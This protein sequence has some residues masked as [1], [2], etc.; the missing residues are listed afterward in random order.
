[1]S[2]GVNGPKK[3][4][5]R[6]YPGDNP[7]AVDD[8]DELAESLENEF[9]KFDA[10]TAKPVTMESEYRHSEPGEARMREVVV[11]SFGLSEKE[12]WE[13]VDKQEIVT[14]EDVT[15]SDS[16]DKVRVT[17]YWEVAPDMELIRDLGRSLKNFAEQRQAH[18]REESACEE[19]KSGTSNSVE[20]EPKKGEEVLTELDPEEEK[21]KAAAA[22]LNAK[23]GLGMV[24]ETTELGRYAA[25]VVGENSEP[26]NPGLEGFRAGYRGYSIERNPYPPQTEEEREWRYGWEEGKGEML[27]KTRDSSGPRGE[28]PETDQVNEYFHYQHND[29][30]QPT[31]PAHDELARRAKFGKNFLTKYN[32]G[33]EYKEK[34]KYGDVHKIAGPRGKLPESDQD[35]EGTSYELGEVDVR[36]IDGSSG[37]ATGYV[38]SPETDEELDVTVE[39][40]YTP[41][42]NQTNRGPGSNEEVEI[43]RVTT[44]DGG[45][46][47]VSDVK[48]DEA[49]LL[50]SVDAYLYDKSL[51]DEND[52]LRFTESKRSR[53]KPITES[54]N[55]LKKLSG[56]L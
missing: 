26:T 6:E 28:L 23:L 8:N 31:R 45:D 48:W 39:F 55:L 46:I 13:W 32:Y 20:R 17:L 49:N 43:T 9:K 7:R 30:G 10:A 21:K 12:V 40:E 14:I 37:T 51:P 42:D 1:M 16:G 52:T 25:A 47:P 41:S 36:S 35:S 56:L 5:K 54:I 53:K 27:D 34:D 44:A 4:W 11:P 19:E 18:V 38:Y 29:K 22:K 2:G 33:D 24:G 50:G 15:V 3:Q